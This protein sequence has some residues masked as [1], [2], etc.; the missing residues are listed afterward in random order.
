MSGSQDHPRVGASL[1][2]TQDLAWSCPNGCNS[3]QRKDPDQHRAEACGARS[4][5]SR[6]SFQSL[7]RMESCG[8]HPLPSPGCG[9]V[10]S[11]IREAPSRPGTQ[12]LCW[13]WSWGHPCL[14]CS[15]L[16]KERGSRHKPHFGTGSLG[17][18]GHSYQFWNRENPPEIVRMPT[19]GQ[20]WE[21]A[22]RRI[23]GQARV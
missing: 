21:Q 5:S 14:A 18:G 17:T 4:G 23:S 22:S 10:G 20:P 2:D 12:G 1:E 19:E 13:G 15:S 11:V 6:R 9:H 3:F 8:S 16:Q 7:L